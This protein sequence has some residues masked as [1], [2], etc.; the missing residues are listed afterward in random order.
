MLGS[1]HARRRDLSQL[2]GHAVP[3]P[4]PALSHFFA[5]YAP[6]TAARKRHLRDEKEFVAQAG[7]ST[8]RCNLKPVSFVKPVGAENEHPGYTGEAQGSNHLVDLLK[9]IE[10]S[11]CARN[12]MVVVTY[13]EFGGQWDHVSPPGQGNHAGPHDVWGPGTRVPALV[14]SPHLDGDFAVDRT[15]PQPSYPTKND[16]TRLEGGLQQVPLRGFEPRFPP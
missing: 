5:A 7:S 4:S 15:E 9:A 12:T 6:G 10:G 8:R 14:L 13:D 3:V 11:R 16:E 1:G 2:P